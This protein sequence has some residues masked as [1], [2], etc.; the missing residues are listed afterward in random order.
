MADP[1]DGAVELGPR[2]ILILAGEPS[3][4]AH[5]AVVAAGLRRRWPGVELVGLGGPAMASAGVT[6]L[7]ELDELAVMG[8]VEVLGRIRFF[9]QL[10][11]ELG[12]LLRANDLDLVLPV[13]YPGLN[14]RVAKKAHQLGVPVVYYIGPQVWAWKAGR[15][16]LLARIADRV[17][18]ILPFEVPIYEAAGA[19]VEY[20]GHPLM[21]SPVPEPPPGF[22][23][24][25]GLAPDRPVLAVFP[26]SRRQ[27]IRRHLE[28]FLRIAREVVSRRPEVQVVV[29]RAPTV[30]VSEF[31]EVGVPV[32]DDVGALR[33]VATAG[34][35]KSGT[36]TLEAALAGLP[37]VVAYKTHPVTYWLA[38]RLV[39]VPHIALA[40]L[41]LG[42]RVV[43]EF[44]QGQ[45]TPT[46][47]A[48][49][50]MPLLD[51]SSQERTGMLKALAGVPAALGGPGSAGRVV[52]LVEDVLVDRRT[53]GRPK[54]PPA[55]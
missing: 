27:E 24:E 53:R 46:E 16:S 39:Q 25:L 28:P 55:P 52:E 40:N 17:A 14:L 29:S 44:V 6:L 2:R 42:S 12:S 5:A 43:P 9:R 50:L 36:S 45:V 8:F 48:N 51:P 32:T 15:A 20:V 19:Q 30:P 1:P 47:V 38:K 49:A 18:V 23:E 11:R 21:E 41:V 26:G 37:F 10:E 3:G 4:D 34:L 7:R 31:T 35:V 33:Q 22:L 13:D 54:S